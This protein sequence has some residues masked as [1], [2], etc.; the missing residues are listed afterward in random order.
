MG[1]LE[2]SNRER[3]PFPRKPIFNHDNTAYHKQAS[4]SLSP[5]LLKTSRSNIYKSSIANQSFRYANQS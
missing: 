5:F 4:R 3:S 2:V 1:N